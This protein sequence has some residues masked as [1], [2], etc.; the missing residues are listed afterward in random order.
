MAGSNAQWRVALGLQ[1]ACGA[2]KDAA[3][4]AVTAVHLLFACRVVMN[5]P[6]FLLGFSSRIS[7]C[8]WLITGL[9]SCVV[10]RLFA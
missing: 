8:N 5:S 4:S 3:I 6:Q 10:D 2:H 7:Y 9:T 1:C